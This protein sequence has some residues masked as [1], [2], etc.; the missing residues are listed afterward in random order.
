MAS[1]AAN[2]PIVVG[3]D[4]SSPS[5][6]ALQ[7]AAR[8]ADRQGRKLVVLHAA[9]RITYTQDAGSGLWKTEEVIADAKEVAGEGR[10]KVL[11]DFPDLEVDTAGSL[12]SAKVALGERSTHA[13]MM[14][15]GSHGRS[16]VGTLLLGSTAYSI[17]G[18]SRC[19]VVIVRD[20][21]STLPGAERPVVVGV[22]GTGGSERAVDAAAVV[23]REWG[24]PLLLATVW[25]PPSG[26]RKP[27]GYSSVEE[28][29]ADHKATA[30]KVNQDLL[31]RATAALDDVE[32]RGTVIEGHPVE[33]LVQAGEQGGLLVLGTHGQGSLA[34]AV[35][36][37]T[38]M[39]VLHESRSPIMVVD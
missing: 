19:P 30:E 34:G 32:I 31:E 5:E 3:Y 36:G 37:S 7:W 15:L 26:N 29:A 27:A 1:V 14:V 13:S 28:A 2:R 33:G 24:A 38:S 10:D 11:E 23:A 39:G 22:N 8:A 21:T 18:Y 12:F 9:E 17:A 20:G 6:A 16:R 25:A 4:G 35:L